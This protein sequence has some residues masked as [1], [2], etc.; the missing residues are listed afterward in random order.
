ME[1][2]GEDSSS[3]G[4]NQLILPN[5]VNPNMRITP[6]LFK[7]TKYKDYAYYREYKE[8][9]KD[10]PKYSDWISENM[11]IMNWILNSMEGGI[12]KSFKNFE[13]AQEFGESIE[14]AY[15][16][17]RN[18]ARILELKMEIANFKQG[19]LS[20]GDYYSKFRALWIELES[21]CYNV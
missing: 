7:G 17:K 4:S 1:S 10:E 3:T 19:A 16:E 5:V 11:V 6:S 9:E 12:A 13:T 14:A 2:K 18:N 21:C 8:P 15:V 20:I